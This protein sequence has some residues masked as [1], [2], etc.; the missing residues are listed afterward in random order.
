M[1]S[2]DIIL[3]CYAAVDWRSHIMLVYSQ[4]LLFLLL[5]SNLVIL[6]VKAV[7]EDHE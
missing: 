6:S 7:I 3:V 4:F 5:S 1:R 2:L